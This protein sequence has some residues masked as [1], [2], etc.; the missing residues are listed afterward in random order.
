[1]PPATLAA[2]MNHLAAE[3]S[4]GPS[5]T[6]TKSIIRA[7]VEEFETFQGSDQAMTPSLALERISDDILPFTLFYR[8]CLQYPPLYRTLRDF[9]LRLGIN[10]E[11]E[12]DN[13]CL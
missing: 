10:V 9:L 11:S 6:M 12:S 2:L 1:M 3:T 7:I 5:L 13:Q 8:E 4:D